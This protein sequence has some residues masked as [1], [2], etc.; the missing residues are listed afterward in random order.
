MRTLPEITKDSPFGRCLTALAKQS[1]TILE[2]GTGSGLGSTTCLVNGLK[3]ETILVTMDIDRN[4]IE[5][6][7]KNLSGNVLIKYG[8]FHQ[9]IR[10]YW[11]PVN[12]IQ[13]REI[14]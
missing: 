6:A 5:V 10:P 12:S 13:H 4:Q 3:P 1:Q 9:T 14:Y 8:T 7:R 2:I 11:H